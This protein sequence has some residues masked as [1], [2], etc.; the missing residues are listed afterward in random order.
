MLLKGEKVFL[1]PIKEDEKDLF[2]DLAMT[3]YGSQFWYD[4]ERKKNR[5]KK[6]FF[7]DWHEGYF[8]MSKPELG[9]CFWIVVK[10]KKIGMINY[11][12]I[13]HNKKEVELDIIIGEKE[14]IGKGYGTDAL[15]TLIKYIFENFAIKKI[16]L[17][18]RSNNH[19]AIKAYQKA[20]FKKRKVLKKKHFFNGEYVDCIRFEILKP[21][22][23]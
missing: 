6:K 18:G 10:N 3:S 7:K 11:N 5:S 23:L 14:N 1:I 2:F 15:K 12:A 13:N 22:I 21:T 4:D 8:D 17:E 20:G 16:W 19:R 9:Q